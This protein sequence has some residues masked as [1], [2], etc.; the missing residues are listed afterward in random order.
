[1]TRIERWGL[2]LTTLFMGGTGLLYGW[3]KYYGQR[4]GDFGPEP[5]PLQGLLQHSH[6]VGAPLMTL[7]LGLV[8]RAHFVPKMRGGKTDGRSTGLLVAFSLAPMLL[9]GYGIQVCTDESLRRLWAWIHGLGSCAYLAAYA[10][11]FLRTWHLRRMV[12]VFKEVEEGQSP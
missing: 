8:L 10:W 3:T 4:M 11:H 9:A 12:V 1:M 2:H 7:A 6:V 5:H